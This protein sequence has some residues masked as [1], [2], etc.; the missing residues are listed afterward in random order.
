MTYDALLVLSF[1]GPEGEADV[2]PF[3]ENVTRG[4]GI[5]RERLLEVAEHY[6]HFGGVSPINGQV[7]ALIEAL[8]RELRAHGITLPIYWGNR[9]WHPMLEDTVRR[10][11]D[12]GVRRALALVT[13]A[14]GSYSG[15]RQYREDVE[16]ARASVGEG[17]PVVEKLRLYFDHPGFAEAWIARVRDALATIE[18]EHA[19]LLFTAHSVPVSMARTAPYEAQ[20]RAMCELVARGVG[21]SAW[22]LCWQSRSGPPQV[23][24]LEPDVLDVLARMASEDR[25]RP[26]V[27]I[28]IGFTSD[29]MEVVWDLDHEAKARADELG[30]RLVR[31]GTVGTHPAFVAGLRELVQEKIAGAPKRALTTLGVDHDPCAA[32]CCPAPQRPSR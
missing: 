6:H 9:N 19:R 8:E 26:V 10:M 29:H 18:G 1:G 25:A 4:R 32:S 13:S 27:V 20:L 12:D 11:K 28:P 17:A 30:L 31:A 7:R 21:T 5:P 23:P 2:M 22:E 15:C 16:R 3:L 24:W 14:F